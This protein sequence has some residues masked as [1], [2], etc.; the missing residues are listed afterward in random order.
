MS[1]Y[2]KGQTHVHTARIPFD[3]CIDEFSNFTEGDNLVELSRDFM[4]RHSKYRTIQKYIFSTSEF[5]MESSA[6]FQQT[7]NSSVE[8]Y[9][10]E[11]RLRYACENFQ[12][13]RFTGAV[14]S[15]YSDDFSWS[16]LK[17]YILKGP[18]FLIC[19]KAKNPEWLSREIHQRLAKRRV[20]RRG[21]AYFILLTDS[22]YADNSIHCDHYSWN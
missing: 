5:R 17:V 4:T 9:S 2:G 15:D 6:Y 19:I 16:N 22:L 3:R 20:P 8:F 10:T 21:T 1:G 18:E 7:S 11:C 14:S 13:G 12:E